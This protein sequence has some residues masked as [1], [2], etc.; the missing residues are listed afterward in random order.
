L[1]AGLAWPDALDPPITRPREIAPSP[2]KGER[3]KMQ[4]GQDNVAYGE[5]VLEIPA[6]LLAS[7][8]VSLATNPTVSAC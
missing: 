3:I 4:I 1:V 5:P 2:S 8:P 6:R 7:M